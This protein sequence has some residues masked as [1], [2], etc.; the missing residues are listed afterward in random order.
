VLA[1]TILRMRDRAYRGI[2]ADDGGGPVD[3]VAYADGR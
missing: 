1:A 2:A 3:T